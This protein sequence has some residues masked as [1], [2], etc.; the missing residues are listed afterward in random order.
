M[1]RLITPRIALVATLGMLLFSS[2]LPAEDT[3]NNNEPYIDRV[4]VKHDTI[5]LTNGRGTEL[6]TIVDID[7]D[8]NLVIEGTSGRRRIEAKDILRIEYHRSIDQVIEKRGDQAIKKNDFTDILQTLKWAKEK[9]AYVAGIALAEKA[10]AVNTE[11]LSIS[12]MAIDLYKLQ[13]DNE[14]LE[15]LARSIIKVDKH[16]TEGFELVASLL[17]NNPARETELKHWLNDWIQLQPTAYQPNKFLAG[18]YERSGELKLAQEAYRK[19]WSLHQDKESALGYARLSLKRGE[20]KKATD[21]AT[22][23]L[24]DPTMASEA[25]AI[26]GSAKLALGQ[27]DEAESLLKEA[28][29]GSLSADSKQYATYNL[30]FIYLHNNK[31]AEA[32]ELWKTLTTPVADL[33]LACLEHRTFDQVDSLPSEGLK[34]LAKEL[35]AAV[36]LE[37]GQFAMAGALDPTNSKRNLFLTQVA[38]VLQSVGSPQSI[39]ELSATNTVESLRW[40]AYGH[41]IAG[42]FNDC[43]KALNQ[44]PEDDGY[45]LAYRLL[46]ADSQKDQ[47]KALDAYKRLTTSPNPPQEW[48][49]KTAAIFDSAND[50]FKDEQF[51][52]PEGDT[53]QSGWKYSAPGTGIR[54]HSQSGKLVFEGRQAVSPDPVSHAYFMVRQDRLKNV[55]LTL[56]MSGVGTAAGGLEI[57][58]EDQNRGVQLAV[59]NDNRLAYRSVRGNGNYGAWESLELQIQ[60]INATLAIEYTN[61]RAFAFMPDDPLRKYPL[62]DDNLGQTATLIVGIW[63]AAE[64]GTDFKIAADSMQIQLKPVGT[65]P[66]RGRFGQE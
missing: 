46:I 52:W 39:R 17:E 11:D 21:A 60:G 50:E 8:Q 58:T 44:L 42:R 33:A 55:K 27:L 62:G 3:P 12:K 64:P 66:T 48:L 7:G 25:K 38:K 16:W 9:E 19:C 59:R 28:V 47:N 14:K 54:I 49:L 5:F 6:G 36:G 40:Q 37:R 65:Q 20:S 32:R 15:T 53:P 26:L 34:Q 29:G 30:G 4:E 63:T 2:P 10:M 43:E 41:F 56:D 61:G 57:L 1:I 45:G 35:N 18:I 24:D 31:G 51:D 13:G 23:L 22:S